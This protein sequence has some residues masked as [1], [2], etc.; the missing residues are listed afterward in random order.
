LKI[1]PIRNSETFVTIIPEERKFHL[2][3]SESLKSHT[4]V[5]AYIPYSLNFILSHRVKKLSI[6]NGTHTLVH[7][8][9][10]SQMFMLYRVEE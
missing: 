8:T 4:S 1:G 6:E 5:Y 10:L 3:R 7:L 9:T 2:H